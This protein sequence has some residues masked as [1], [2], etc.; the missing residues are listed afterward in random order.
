VHE[1]SFRNGFFEKTCGNNKLFFKSLNENY[2]MR[3]SLIFRDSTSTDVVTKKQSPTSR[4]RGS[5][6]PPNIFTYLIQ[7]DD[8]NEWWN[9]SMDQHQKIAHNWGDENLVFIGPGDNVYYKAQSEKNRMLALGL[10]LNPPNYTGGDPSTKSDVT[11]SVQFLYWG[12]RKRKRGKEWRLVESPLK[13]LIEMYLS[14][15]R[16][17]LE[18]L[19]VR[20]HSDGT[21]F[22][23]NTE[24]HEKIPIKI[25][26]SLPEH[27]GAST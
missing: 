22:V 21:W 19:Q 3:D 7:G 9:P 18:T 12:D 11:E 1:T 25:I 20:I 10:N 2:V 24:L 15:Q 4:Y 8:P 16:K 26:R 17:E 14:G 5:I 6:A 13:L 23:Q 27:S